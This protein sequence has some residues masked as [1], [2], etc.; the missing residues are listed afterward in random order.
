[1]LPSPHISFG[2]CSLGQRGATFPSFYCTSASASACCVFL[3]LRPIPQAEELGSILL[4]TDLSVT[5]LLNSCLAKFQRGRETVPQLCSSRTFSLS[6]NRM[7]QADLKG[8]KPSS[9]GTQECQ[10][11]TEAQREAQDSL[12]KRDNLVH[13]RGKGRG[14]TGSPWGPTKK[15]QR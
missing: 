5:L 11:A 2:S 13:L 9:L 12:W 10:K 1:M 4:C 3:H 6:L 7:T 14:R 15:A 8:R